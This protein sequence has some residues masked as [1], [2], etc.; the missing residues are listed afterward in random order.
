MGGPA[1]ACEWVL[2]ALP[3]ELDACLLSALPLDCT[4]DIG[5]SRLLGTTKGNHVDIDS[6]DQWACENLSSPSLASSQSSSSGDE[7]AEPVF[8]DTAAT[9]LSPERLTLEETQQLAVLRTALSYFCLSRRV[10]G[11]GAFDQLL[12]A[13]LV[14]RM[15]LERATLLT[16]A[17]LF[18][19]VDA[20][21]ELMKVH[22]RQLDVSTALLE[23][24]RLCVP[25]LSSWTHSE[26]R[27][28][29]LVVLEAYAALLS[30]GI[31][32]EAASLAFL[33]LLGEFS[34][35]QVRCCETMQEPSRSRVC[36]TV[37][38]QPV[39][40]L[41]YTL[42]FLGSNHDSVR[43]LAAQNVAVFLSGQKPVRLQSLLPL[44]SKHLGADLSKKDEHYSGCLV[45]ATALANA[46]IALG[47][48]RG[49]K[50]VAVLLQ[51]IRD[52]SLP[53]KLAAKVLGFADS[54]QEPWAVVH[55]PAVVYYWLKQGLPLDELPIMALGCSSAT[56]FWNCHW[57]H[58]LPAAVEC[59]DSGAVQLVSDSVGLPAEELLLKVAP[60][61][62]SR[63]LPHSEPLRFLE[64]QLSPEVVE[65]L[66]VD[67][68][69]EVLVCVLQLACDIPGHAALSHDELYPPC[70]AE[71]QVQDYLRLLERT[72][73]GD[74]LAVLLRKRDGIQLV[75]E[76]LQQ[77]AG[78]SLAA[79][80]HLV[81][82]LSPARPN[83]LGGS[84]CFV[85]RTLTRQLLRKLPVQGSADDT[86]RLV[87]RLLRKLYAT[88]TLYKETARSLPV[89]INA[90]APF[91]DDESTGGEVQ[92]LVEILL[93]NEQLEAEV[94]RLSPL[95]LTQAPLSAVHSRLK[96]G[97]L[98]QV[99]KVSCPN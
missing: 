23:L 9:V 95:T 42:R 47:P 5:A 73:G 61:L 25:A 2:A 32:N 67:R 66:L 54:K 90:L 21:R 37:D 76:G 94:L 85:L 22:C 86:V 82:M 69:P 33:R 44:L 65:Q 16:E 79:L 74:L 26:L 17:E 71:G 46:A 8:S 50:A 18:S 56:Q 52:R 77:P 63:G 29:F 14:L 91:V 51:A 49:G 64:Q 27:Q 62:L 1:Q 53:S 6:E 11:R 57:V 70:L 30:Q 4:D 12:Q 43:T 98:T 81:A 48:H 38:R 24:A 87:A 28:C 34:L 93:S 15:L 31:L 78:P 35:F 10:A 88:T 59:C 72:C 60:S 92:H 40:M 36:L 84:E 41:E 80:N 39:S 89:I 68:L 75:L 20:L 55:L 45:Y 3:Q 13:L 19:L 99:S 7:F 97:C 58:V 83:D 96:K